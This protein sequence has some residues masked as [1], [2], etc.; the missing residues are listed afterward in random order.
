MSIQFLVIVERSWE[1]TK[2]QWWFTSFVAWR[3]LIM[4]IN[5][6]LNFFPSLAVG[7]WTTLW[8]H[9]AQKVFYPLVIWYAVGLCFITTRAHTQYDDC[10]CQTAHGSARAST[11]YLTEYTKNTEGREPLCDQVANRYNSTTLAYLRVSTFHTRCS[12]NVIIYALC[13]PLCSCMETT[14]T[15]KL[16]N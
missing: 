3:R 14:I 4:A 16:C 2:F 13:H 1:Y 6:C 5:Y 15:L 10:A 9:A 7:T 12:W 11:I 8:R